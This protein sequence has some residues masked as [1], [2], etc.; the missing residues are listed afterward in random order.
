MRGWVGGEIDRGWGIG[1]DGKS[2][3]Q[4]WGEGQQMIGR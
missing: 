4:S 3:S 2:E 1:R